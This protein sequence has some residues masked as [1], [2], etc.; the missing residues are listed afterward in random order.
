VIELRIP[1]PRPIRSVKGSGRSIETFDP[2]TGVIRI[3][4]DIGKLT[5]T[6]GY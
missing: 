3:P 2:Q 5:L 4:G 6:I 1:V